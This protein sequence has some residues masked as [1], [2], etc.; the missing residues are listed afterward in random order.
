[1]ADAQHDHE[2]LPSFS[3]QL[4]TTPSVARAVQERDNATSIIF[5]TIVEQLEELR[6]ENGVL[7]FEHPEIPLINSG[8]LH[9]LV[10]DVSYL[11]SG[12]GAVAPAS[13]MP[14]LLRLL[15]LLQG[16]PSEKRAVR[17]HVLFD[18][19]AWV[20]ALN[21]VLLINPMII[22]LPPVLVQSV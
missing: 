20:H 3:V 19:A 5:S 2:A 9:W 16:T 4:F 10:N 15:A 11:I 14:A 18:A 1:M 21:L 12:S 17:E 8:R 7:S 13:I 6:G 22:A